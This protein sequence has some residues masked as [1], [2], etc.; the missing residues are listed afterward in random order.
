MRQKKNAYRSY[1]EAIPLDQVDLNPTFQNKLQFNGYTG[2]AIIHLDQP[3]YQK[4]P[5]LQKDQRG[6]HYISPHN[7]VKYA[8]VKKLSN[9][10]VGHGKN[11]YSRYRYKIS[12]KFTQPQLEFIIKTLF[13]NVQAESYIYD[14]D[15]DLPVP[16]FHQDVINLPTSLIEPRDGFSEAF[17]EM[18]TL[19]ANFNPQQITD[20][21][22]VETVIQKQYTMHNVYCESITSA[23]WD[24]LLLETKDSHA[25]ILREEIGALVSEEKNES[26]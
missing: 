24:A 15:L 17:K 7:T 23:K 14:H 13:N 1:V 26:D 4:L 25:V 22:E 16:Q 18:I 2:E 5:N 19:V 20:W 6:G 12:I 21:Q 10:K 8:K 3:S 11:S 9:G